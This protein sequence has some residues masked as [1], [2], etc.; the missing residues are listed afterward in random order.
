MIIS[1]LGV[2]RVRN[3]VEQTV[4]PAAGINLITGANAAGK[5]SI[6][7]AIHILA[8][9]ASFRATRL[10]QAIQHGQNELMVTGTVLDSH[11]SEHRLGIQRRR[12]ET[13]VRVDGRDVRNLSE[14]ARH[15]PVQVINTE[16]QRLLH[17]G[18]KVR[19][20]FL[21]WS[22]FHV[23]H[24]YYRDWRRYD[25]ALRQRNAALRQGDLRLAGSWEPELCSAAERV[26]AARRRFIER[27]IPELASLV[28]GWLPDTEITLHYRRGW[29]AGESL[30]ELLAAGRSRERETGYTLYGSHRAD[31]VIRAE[32]SDA[33]HWLS[34]GQ[35]KTLAIAMLLAQS[36]IVAGCGTVP[37][38][39]IDD[40][41]AELDSEHAARILSVVAAGPAQCF[42]TAID[43][44]T[45]PM[46]PARWFEITEGRVREMV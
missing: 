14:L 10:D 41:R 17:D 27:L 29:A 22:V 37:L 43:R 4:V 2:H 9:A 44:A 12:G 16:S 32:G 8:R 39:L 15:L 45:V 38:L 23:E 28:D 35:Q 42:V 30:A 18:P 13:R 11:G 1:R 21:N 31:L 19:R 6:L 5:T 7:E 34:R 36:R 24:D 3:L 26:D 33:Q 25:R 20:S 46:E 40:L